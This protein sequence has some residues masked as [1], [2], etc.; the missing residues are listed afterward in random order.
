MLTLFHKVGMI[1][2]MQDNIENEIG[3]T[4]RGMRSRRSRGCLHV[5]LLLL[6]VG[7]FP[8]LWRWG[9]KTAYA[10]E[11][12]LLDEAPRNPTAIVFGAAVYPNGRLSPVLRDRVETAVQL[13]QSGRVESIIVSGDNREDHYNEPQAMMAYAI[14]R[15]VPE[16]A[17]QPD[18]AGL[19]TYDTCYRARHVFGVETAVLIT[20]AFHLPRAIFTCRQLGVDALGVAADLRPYRAAEWYEFRETFATLVALWDILRNQPATIMGDPISLK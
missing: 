13:Y 9:V 19:R 16:E 17:I 12:F 3:K 7:S 5:L 6:L 14:S 10:N 15:G 18:Y 4:Q 11:I 2:G 20:Q 8:W 1:V